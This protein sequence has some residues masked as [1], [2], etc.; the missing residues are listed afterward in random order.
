M[1]SASGRRSFGNTEASGQAQ[2]A[3][4]NAREQAVQTS[5][6]L[7]TLIARHA[8]A[9]RHAADTYERAEAAATELA[10]N[11]ARSIDES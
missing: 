4:L 1:R 5:S 11:A 9:L 7:R 6:Q 10:T 8:E 3:Y 2:A